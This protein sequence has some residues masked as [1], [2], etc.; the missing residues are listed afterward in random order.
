MIHKVIIVLLTLAAVGAATVAVWSV[1][2]PSLFYFEYRGWWVRYLGGIDCRSGPAPTW[3]VHLRPGRIEV[4]HTTMSEPA[5]QTTYTTLPPVWPLALL[6][7]AYPIITFIH[8]PLRR[9]RR[10]RRDLCLKCGYDL[11]GNVSGV[12]PECGGAV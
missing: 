6:F 8:G 11:T 10:R 1:F 12:C 7:A 2:K 5:Y 4:E 3:V 9:W